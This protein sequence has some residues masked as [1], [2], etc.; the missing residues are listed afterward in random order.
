MIKL[1]AIKEINLHYKPIPEAPRELRSC[2]LW[3]APVNAHDQVYI[4]RGLLNQCV[5][6]ALECS[7]PL[8]SVPWWLP[9]GS[10][11]C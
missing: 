4:T 5:G 1:H 8:V 10:L 9:I 2:L 11:R 6:V 7:G 3:I